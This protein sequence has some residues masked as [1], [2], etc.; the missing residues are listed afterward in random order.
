[1]P[2]NRS[3][4]SYLCVFKNER[5]DIM[6]HLTVAEILKLDIFKEV[7]IQA[8][9]AGLSHSVTGITTAEDPDLIQWLNGGE[10]LLT[11]L[12]IATIGPLSF[13][14]YIDILARR[15]ISAL[16]I[17]TSSHLPKIPKE[18]L[19][20]GNAYGIPIIE[21]P[22]SV[23]FFDVVSSVMKVLLENKA[24]Y[25]I[26]LQN[27]LSQ[28]L[29]SGCQ[30]QDILEY[31]VKYIPAQVCLTDS[32]KNVTHWA[33]SPDFHSEQAV[34][35][36]IT[37][38]IMCMGEVNGY[39]NAAANQYLDE[40]LEALLKTAANLLAVFFL[41]KYYVAEIE[42]K[43]ISV[44]LGDLFHQSL[45]EKQLEEKAE[46]YGWKKEDSFLIIS[47]QAQPSSGEK[48]EE[49]LMELT[50]LIPK[51]SYYFC[52]Q[53]DFL[54]ILY[55]SQGPTAAADMYN[56]VMNTLAA[57]KHYIEKLHSSSSFFAGI[58][59]PAAGVA[60]LTK[61]VQEADDALQFGKIFQNDIVKYEDLGALRMLASYSHRENLE[62]I[63]PPA[64]RKLAEYDKA[65]N[66][67]YLETLDSLLGNNLNL[68]KTAKELFIHYKTMLHRMDRICQIAE[69][70][71]DDRQTRLD[72]ELGVKLY[73]ML[74]K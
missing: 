4:F 55:H 11:S 53:D 61:K 13:D 71:L 38:P 69:I 62:Q 24:Q 65:N 44:F 6:K 36:R 51:N 74:P 23:R 63:I 5:S 68:S 32:E 26:E 59:S 14:K 57:L 42:Q 17:K 15:N 1:M 35:D 64:V 18:I 34:A 8:G 49:L 66:T 19:E 16:I 50:R 31:L 70:S 47:I 27:N 7:T 28:L 12:Y 40:N 3:V 52:I 58:S 33:S 37:L 21:L 45:S 46:G 41:K 48:S 39:L 60:Q 10:I 67:Q 25:Y 56:A 9:A 22:P 2:L 54:H 72:I 20:K 73:M 30:E 29:A 43:Y